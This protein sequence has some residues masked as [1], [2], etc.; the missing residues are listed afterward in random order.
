MFVCSYFLDVVL[1]NRGIYFTRHS[2]GEDKCKKEEFLDGLIASATKDGKHRQ[3]LSGRQRRGDQTD[4]DEASVGSRSFLSDLLASNQSAR[5]RRGSTIL[6]GKSLATDASSLTFSATSNEVSSL[7]IYK[8]RGRAPLRRSHYSERGDDSTAY[9]FTSTMHRYIVDGGAFLPKTRKEWVVMVMLAVLLSPLVHVVLV[10]SLGHF[11]LRYSDSLRGTGEEDIPTLTVAS[12]EER[13]KKE[14]EMQRA[15]AW[16][17]SAQVMLAKS[18]SLGENVILIPDADWIELQ[19]RRRRSGAALRPPKRLPL[20]P[21]LDPPH[22]TS[23][24]TNSNGVVLYSLTAQNGH[25]LPAGSDNGDSLAMQTQL[26]EAIQLLTKPTPLDA[27]PCWSHNSLAQ[28]RE[29]GYAVL[30]SLGE[31]RQARRQ[32]AQ[33]AQKFG[34]STAYEFATVDGQSGG[35]RGATEEE[36][37]EGKDGSSL[38]V[39]ALP[40]SRSDAMVRRTLPVAAPYQEWEEDVDELSSVVLRRVGVLPVEDELTMQEWEGPPLEQVIWKRGASVNVLDNRR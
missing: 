11:G 8:D 16:V 34:Q 17:G 32:V 1:T 40:N 9:T 29:D 35:L 7:N 4:D 39:P 20:P 5:K 13:R 36:R 28:F 26:W 3:H 24:T 21:V 15:D 18:S 33:L 27:W 12:P 25:N 14:Q 2:N 30:Y 23:L 31:W 19:I 6:T 22:D 38:V 10:N 37:L